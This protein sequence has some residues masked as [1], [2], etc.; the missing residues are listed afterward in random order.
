MKYLNHLPVAILPFE[1][2]KFLE[3]I[4]DM[5]ITLFN[6]DVINIPKGF[7]FDGRST[8]YLLRWLFPRLNKNLLP[9]LIHD[10]LYYSDYKRKELGDKKAKEFA[11]NEMK[12][13]QNQMKQCQIE[14]DACYDAVH[15]FGWKVF[16]TWKS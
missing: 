5:E 2:D 10:W 1:D 14:R 16:K 12:Y 7:R 9:Y 6:G 13:W 11:D 8:P 15:F 4:E 3:T